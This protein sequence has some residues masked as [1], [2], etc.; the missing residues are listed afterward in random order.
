MKKY[1]RG[2]GLDWF[3]IIFLSLVAFGYDSCHSNRDKDFFLSH[4]QKIS[5][6]VPDYFKALF[7]KESQGK[8]R[9]LKTVE[10][11][12]KDTISNFLYDGKFIIQLYKISNS[13]SYSLKNTINEIYAENKQVA[14]VYFDGNFES[15]IYILDRTD[16][17]R[18]DIPHNIFISF[19]NSNLTNILKNDSVADY[20]TQSHN[21]SIG[22]NSLRQQEF[23]IESKKNPGRP[24][25]LEVLFLKENRSLF[26]VFISSVTGS[27]FP[28][29]TFFKSLF[30]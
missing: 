19:N 15:Q 8:L 16:V 6:N 23:Y 28:E 29:R 12:Y 20:Y 18:A 11:G 7:T 3:F 13:Y 25:N 22:Y 4:P 2:Q 1:S 9:L 27:N 17:S 21:L 14:Q 30:K 26:V 5:K 24:F 10:R